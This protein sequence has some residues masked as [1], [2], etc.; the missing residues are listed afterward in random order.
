MSVSKPQT[1]LGQK[2]TQLPQELTIWESFFNEHPIKTFI[3]LGTGNGGMSLF[4]ALQCYQRKIFFHTFDN[5]KFFDFDN[6]VPPLLNLWGSFHFVDLFSDEGKR[7][8]VE[9]IDT[10]P[11]PMAIFF[12]NGDKPREWGMFAGLT[13]PGDFLIVHD[14]DNEFLDKDIGEVVVNKIL[15]EERDER[16]PNWMTM[17]FVRP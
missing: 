10:F 15:L 4:F 6:G 8:V 9:L 13:H 16:K 11:H 2:M 7:Q 17:F 1:F 14:W 3:E 5:Q 12:D